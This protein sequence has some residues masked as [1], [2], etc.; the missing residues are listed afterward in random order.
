MSFVDHVLRRWQDR[1]SVRAEHCLEPTLRRRIDRLPQ[2]L[3][4]R[5]SR[6]GDIGERIEQASRRAWGRDYI[7]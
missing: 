2:R 5:R 6:P 1:A 3:A 7:P 4:D